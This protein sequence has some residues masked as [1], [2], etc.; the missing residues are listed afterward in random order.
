MLI[1]FGDFVDGA[2]AKVGDPYI[3]LLPLT[4]PAEAHSDFVTVRMG[5]IDRT[6]DLK[7]LPAVPY[8]GDDDEDEDEAEPE[9]EI[10]KYLPYIIGGSVAVG[11]VLLVLIVAASYRRSSKKYRRLHEPAP[12][13]LPTTNAPAPFQQYQPTRR[14]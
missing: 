12:G 7:L 3:Q 10:K 11:V 8:N 9:D 14:Y 13:G 4:E 1:D 2:L 5:G 6:A